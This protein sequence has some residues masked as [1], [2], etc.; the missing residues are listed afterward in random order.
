M[1]EKQKKVMDAIDRYWG[2]DNKQQ[3]TSSWHDKQDC[4]EVI[5]GILS[6]GEG[7]VQRCSICECRGNVPNNFYTGITG[8]TSADPV[9]CRACKG[10][11]IISLPQS[12]TG[13]EKDKGYRC[14][15]IDGCEK[16]LS[17]LSLDIQKKI[18]FYE[19]L[20]LRKEGE[21]K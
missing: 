4:L 9:T 12:G 2:F 19:N 11:G 13:E 10:S 18:T 20:A 21:G 17:E 7:Q 3:P 15:Y 5:L 6:A 16:I 1:N 8:S 14:G